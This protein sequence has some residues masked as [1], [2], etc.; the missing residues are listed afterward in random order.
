MYSIIFRQIEQ[1]RYDIARRNPKYAALGAT[2]D[3]V[4]YYDLDIEDGRLQNHCDGYSGC[5][6]K[7]VTCGQLY[8][9]QT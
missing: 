7:S 6:L 1:F 8:Q 2:I 3:E 9:F 4:T 5:G